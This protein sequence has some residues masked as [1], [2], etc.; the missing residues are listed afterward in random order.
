[1]RSY[2]IDNRQGKVDEVTFF[3][4]LEMIAPGYHKNSWVIEPFSAIHP[5][6]LKKIVVKSNIIP[7]LVRLICGGLKVTLLPDSKEDWE[8]YTEELVRSTQER[9]SVVMSDY[10]AG[11]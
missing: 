1:M 8:G 3:E 11:V 7:E 2:C 4:R 5:R 9:N 10:D 6:P